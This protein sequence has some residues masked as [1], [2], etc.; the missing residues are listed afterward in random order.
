MLLPLPTVM[1]TGLNATYWNQFTSNMELRNRHQTAAA[2]Q[3]LIKFKYNSSFHLIESAKLWELW[4]V[5]MRS[6]L[7]WDKKWWVGGPYL[8]D[9]NSMFCSSK[10]FA[11]LSVFLSLSLAYF[12]LSH[13]LLQPEILLSSPPTHTRRHIDTGTTIFAH[14]RRREGEKD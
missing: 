9:W 13:L 6:N 12:Y 4:I 10:C 8:W 7:L 5:K 1:L 11:S 3:Y 14:V 2:G